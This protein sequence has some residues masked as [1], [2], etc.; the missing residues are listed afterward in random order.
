MLATVLFFVT[1][2]R[3][4]GFW[5]CLACGVVA[6]LVLGALDRRGPDSGEN[7]KDSHE[8][9]P[10]E[11]TEAP[12][13]QVLDLCVRFIWSLL[14]GVALY[15][16]LTKSDDHGNSAALVLG[17]IGCWYLG[18]RAMRPSQPAPRAPASGYRV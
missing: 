11:E 14:K 17:F 9:E 8:E 3:G 2:E 13:E 10:R 1:W 15:W 16:L 6:G 12:P 18:F 7:K 5:V 4:H